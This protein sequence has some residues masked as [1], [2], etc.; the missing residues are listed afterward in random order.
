MFISLKGWLD[1]R[2]KSL[3]CRVFQRERFE[4]RDERWTWTAATVVP[5]AQRDVFP[6]E[7]AENVLRKFN[8][9]PVETMSQHL[10]HHPL[11]FWS[12]FCFISATL[13]RRAV[14]RK[15]KD[16]RLSSICLI[17]IYVDWL[18]IIRNRSHG[19]S[20]N[21]RA[22]RICGQVYRRARHYFIGEWKAHPVDNF[23]I[24][25]RKKK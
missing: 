17:L 9:N 6:H 10:G 16:R 19:R 20:G 7:P 3:G 21:L 4:W 22:D 15:T 14:L 2:S 1:G 13:S 8:G 5:R 12:L 25:K 11:R 18:P 24:F 23:C